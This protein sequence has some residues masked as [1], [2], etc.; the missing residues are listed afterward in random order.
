MSLFAH[1]RFLRSVLWLDC[2]S[3]AGTAL[4][5]L[6]AAATLSALLGLPMHL[7]VG[8]G[9]VLLVFVG[10]AAY[11][12]NCEP[13]PRHG[14][15]LLVAGNFAWVAG[16]LVLL[17]TGAAGNSWGQAYVAVQAVFVGVLAEL[18][19]MGLRHARPVGWN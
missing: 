17:F 2:A 5:Q 6:S 7:L 4:L 18:Q 8:S 16:C 1:P 10:G 9:L 3:G 11:L 15:T 14:V 13:I 19:W 12:A